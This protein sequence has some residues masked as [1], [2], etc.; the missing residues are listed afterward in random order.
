MK[1]VRSIIS[2]ECSVRELEFS[3]TIMLTMR[4]FVRVCVRARAL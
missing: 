1:R 4:L 2:D 3:E